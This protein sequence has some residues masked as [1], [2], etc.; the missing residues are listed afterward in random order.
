MSVLLDVEHLTVSFQT[1]KGI[2][3]AV[4]DISFSVY[5]GETLAVVG[6]SGCG[7]SVTMRSI[8]R[9]IPNPPGK[10]HAAGI[11]FKGKDLCLLPNEEMRKIRGNDIAM[12]FQDASVALNPVLTIGKQ[13]SESLIE[14]KKMRYQ[15]AMKRSEELLHLVGITNPAQRLHEYPYQFSGGMKQRVMIAIALSCEPSLL[16]A[17][18]PTTALDVTIQMQIIQLMQRLQKILNMTVIWIT[19]D[20]GI[21]ARIADRVMVMYAGHIVERASVQDI[22]A[23]TAHPYTRGLLTSLPR[24]DKRAKRLLSISGQPPDLLVK[25]DGCPFYDRCDYRVER[26]RKAM[27]LLETVHKGHESACW[28]KDALV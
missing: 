27:P 2:V 17:D 16:I 18:E 6:E 7:K 4:N 1:Q 20:L 5:S 13:L 26:C 12:V 25:R 14:H 11:Y 10:V 15:D 28:E 19:H 23:K 22:Y 9:L 3:H 8:M 21:V 24:I